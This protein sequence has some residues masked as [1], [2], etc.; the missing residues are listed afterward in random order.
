MLDEFCTAY[1]NDI[2][3]YSNFK[4]EHQTHIQKVLA[5]L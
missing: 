3:I 2:L 4:K 5:A 1:I